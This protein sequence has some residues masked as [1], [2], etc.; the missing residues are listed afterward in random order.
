MIPQ[1]AARTERGI[2]RVNQDDMLIQAACAVRPYLHSLVGQ[3]AYE[4]DKHLVELLRNGEAEAI[5][6][7]FR[8][9]DDLLDWLS[10]YFET[11]YPPQVAVH[12]TRNGVGYQPSPGRG[13]SIPP[14][15]YC[16]P[17][18]GLYVWYR[19]DPGEAVPRC[20]D[21]PGHFVV[22]S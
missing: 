13:V 5:G 22:P 2:A 10:S 14:A 3:D 4:F 8:A 1:F 15:K 7:L 20:P 6:D 19:V 12:D 17:V 21:H 18:D 16:C 9:K 11:G